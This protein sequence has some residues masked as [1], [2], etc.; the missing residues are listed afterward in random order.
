MLIIQN[1]MG[2]L[3]SP[4]VIAVP[5]TGSARKPPM[6][7]HVAIAA[8][9]GGL[10]RQ[11]VVLCEQVRTLQKSRFQRYLGT[12]SPAD[13]RRVERALS[14]SMDMASAGEKE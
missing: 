11:S 3:H 9:E 5:L 12:L 6:R 1:D 2:N 8:G 7:T 4:T 10:S 14:V 13:M